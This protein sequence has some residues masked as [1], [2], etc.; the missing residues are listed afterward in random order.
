MIE[1]AGS[2]RFAFS[3]IF[4]QSLVPISFDRPQVYPLLVVF[5]LQAAGNCSKTLFITIKAR[6]LRHPHIPDPQMGI[7]GSL[8]TSAIAY[9]VVSVIMIP[10]S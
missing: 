8:N 6:L 2:V 7:L 1:A 10:G 5:A 9:A 4:S 3:A